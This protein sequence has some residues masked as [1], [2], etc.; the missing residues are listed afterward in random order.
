MT[1][2]AVKDLKSPRALR[3]RL[4]ADGEL[5]LTNN[6][7]P[8]AL[9]LNMGEADDPIALLNA[10]RNARSQ[11]A[12]TRIRESARKTGRSR[13]SLAAINRVIDEARGERRSRPG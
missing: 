8:M 3:Q 2:I 13:M 12:M 4:A 1:Y 10:V 11:L 9:M 6:G 5:L 7:K